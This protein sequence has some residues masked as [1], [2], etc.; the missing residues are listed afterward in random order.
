MGAAVAFEPNPATF[1]ILEANSRNDS[2]WVNY[3]LAVGDVAGTARFNIAGNLG[4]SSSLLAPQVSRICVEK[5]VEVE[6]CTLAPYFEK[7]GVDGSFIKLDVQGFEERVLLGVGE[8][9][10]H[11]S[12]VYLEAVLEPDYQNSCMFD[13]LH[14]FVQRKNFALVHTEPGYVDPA[15]GY[16]RE[17]NCMYVNKK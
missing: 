15:T 3:N 13:D 11:V 6:V 1:R 10:T 5:T 4:E 7:H 8:A 12:G 16:M 9:L 14:A 2:N 17:I